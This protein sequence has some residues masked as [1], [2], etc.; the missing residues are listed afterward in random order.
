MPVLVC[1]DG[2]PSATRAIETVATLMQDREVV[3]VHVWNPPLPYLSDSFSEPEGTSAAAHDELDATTHDF[4]Q[5]RLNEGESAARAA[6]LNVTP[7][8]ERSDASVAQAIL[9]VASA[10]AAEV[11]VVGTH[12]HTP[13]QSKPLGS[14]S[15]DVLRH[16]T[17]PVL[18]VPS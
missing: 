9:S 12:G 17:L 8:L 4:A 1:Y 13:V 10:L 15:D 7:R 5:K 2:S 3:L 14:V 11:I 16:A 18:I 6:G